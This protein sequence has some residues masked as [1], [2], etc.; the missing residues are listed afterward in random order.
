MATKKRAE[1]KRKLHAV[2][3]EQGVPDE[4]QS[5]RPTKE[6]GRDQISINFVLVLSPARVM[7][8]LVRR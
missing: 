7:N 8:R 6:D 2:R 3:E 4:F 5:F 1:R